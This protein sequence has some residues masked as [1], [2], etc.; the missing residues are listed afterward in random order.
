MSLP[1]NFEISCIWKITVLYDLGET[2]KPINPRGVPSG[3]SDMVL[4]KSPITNARM[5]NRTCLLRPN[6]SNSIS[7]SKSRSRAGRPAGVKRCAD[8]STTFALSSTLFTPFVRLNCCSWEF[9]PETQIAE[10][11][12]LLHALQTSSWLKDP[13]RPS[14]LK[15]SNDEV[16]HRWIWR[17]AQ[18]QPWF[19]D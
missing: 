6:S 3:V 11:Y 12:G 9:K 8:I 15:R 4:T 14:S 10:L 13:F 18:V 1:Y 17:R 5:D 19:L 2:K 7:C 16:Q